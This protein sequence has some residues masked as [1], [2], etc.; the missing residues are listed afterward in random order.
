MAYERSPSTGTT[1]GT[2]SLAELKV[3][4]PPV[5]S[6]LRIHQVGWR[7]DGKMESLADVAK[8]AGQDF[9]PYIDYIFPGCNKTP[10]CVNWYLNYRYGCPETEDGKNRRFRGGET[11][12]LPKLDWKDAKPA[13]PP[14]TP[15]RLGFYD[16]QAAV[17]YARR[18]ARG[19]NP[20]YPETHNGSDCTNFVSQAL[21]AGGWTMVG[22][23]T[24]WDYND[25][26]MWWYGKVTKD[27]YDKWYNNA[28]D[29]IKD[30]IGGGRPPQSEIYRYSQTWS[31]ANNFATFMRLSWRG[32][33]RNSYK[34]LEPGDIITE[35]DRD[36]GY[37][38][39]VMFVVG[40][41]ADDL[42]YAQH[43]DNDIRWFSTRHPDGRHNQFPAKEFR[44]W[45]IQDRLQ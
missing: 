36:K 27:E 29:A 22:E 7:S 40:R 24:V 38:S 8:H 20:A 32:F 28:I 19:I 9:W 25:P 30:Y 6:I 31:G 3:Y 14:K 41:T 15:R 13:D 2:T 37:Y 45:K 42:E 34:E 4:K 11:L 5:A 12:P 21:F 43:T 44:W 35:Y 39:H 23:G 1:V 18:W 26:R 17:S 33:Q 10:E 16:R